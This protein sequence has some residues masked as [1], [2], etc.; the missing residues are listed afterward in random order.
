MEVN[1]LGLLVQLY[2][3]PLVDVPP[4]LELDPLQIVCADPTLGVGFE[5]TLMDMLDESLHPPEF[6]STTFRETV[7]VLDPK[8]TLIELVPA[9]EAIVAPLMVHL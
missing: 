3:C 5:R 7:P 8:D 4:M 6:V 2:V 9:P 1:P